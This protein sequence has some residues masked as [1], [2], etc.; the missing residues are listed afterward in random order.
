MNM[1]Q[2]RWLDVVKDYGY[3]ILYHPGK[4]NVVAD[5]LSRK[6]ASDL[7]RG[8]CLRNTIESLLLDLIKESRAEGIWREN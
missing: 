6:T 8:L 2:H 5:A 7:V 4:V 1:R 3:D